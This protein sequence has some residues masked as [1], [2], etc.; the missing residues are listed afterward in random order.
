[1]EK[2]LNNSLIISCCVVGAE[3]TRQSYPYLPI[4][5]DEIAAAADEAVSAGASIIHLHVRDENGNPTQR[6]DVFEKVS[7]KIRERCDCILQ[8][9]TG[10]AVGTPVADRCAPLKLKPE[11]GTLS[12]GTMNF[13]SDIFENSEQTITSIAHSLVENGVMPELEIFDYGMIEMVERYVKKGIIPH[14][15]HV[16]FVLGVPGGMSGEAR[17]LVMLVDQL[18]RLRAKLSFEKQV[19][20][21]VEGSWT[22]AGVGRYQLP[23]ATQAIAMGGH[24][25]IGVE[26]NIYYRKGEMAKSN[27]E[28]ISRVVRIAREFDR[29]PATV[30]EVR[31]FFKLR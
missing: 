6:I 15:F 29:A 10:G 19:I 11:M 22:V 26:D 18:E 20:N 30:E 13:G 21:Q 1:M 3:H 7:A 12:M 31:K 24:V 5:P 23:L 17:N 2:S 25:R 16:D 28:L 27:A 9:S 14:R 4:T 8:F